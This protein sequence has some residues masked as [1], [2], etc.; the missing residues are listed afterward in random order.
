MFTHFSTYV[1]HTHHSINYEAIA[2][3]IFIYQSLAFIQNFDALWN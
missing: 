3:K 1:S 2:I